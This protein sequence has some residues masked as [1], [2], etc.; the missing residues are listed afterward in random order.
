MIPLGHGEIGRLACPRC[1]GS[2]AAADDTVACRGCGARYEVR[3]GVPDLLPWSGGEP[4]REWARWR[5]KL[6]LLQQWRRRTWNRSQQAEVRQEVADGLALRFFEFVRV[7]EGGSVLDIGCGSG[8]LRRHLER[9]GYWGL[10]PLFVMPSAAPAA[11]AAGG[12]STTVFLRGVGE[13]L[14][15]ADAGFEVVLLSQTL[16]HCLDPARVI[17]EAH[18]V[19]KP[20]GLLG[21]MQS[22]HVATP[23]PPL[24]QLRAAAGRWK[25]R[26][27]G[28]WRPDDADTKTN[29]LARSDL[30]ALVGSEFSIDESLTCGSVMFLRAFKRE[31]PA[32]R[33][34]LGEHGG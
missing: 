33:A 28:R 29:P 20:G 4:G 13:C 15:L 31:R 6:E 24:A 11:G 2:L 12:S 30:T 18:R 26:L 23:S 7:P 21:I 25:A 9:H 17:R 3:V 22:L 10:D 32:S 14:P 34:G 5:E 1:R 16:D 8:E 19:L 27:L